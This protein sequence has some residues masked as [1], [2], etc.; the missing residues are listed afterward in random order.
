MFQTVPVVPEKLPG[1]PFDV[2]ATGRLA[3]FPADGDPDPR[4]IGLTGRINEDEMSI[5]YFTSGP[6]QP[7][8]IGTG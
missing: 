2:I 7:D 8:K 3:D 6:G 4:A 5:L 1:Q